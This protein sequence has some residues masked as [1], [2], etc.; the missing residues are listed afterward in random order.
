MTSCHSGTAKARFLAMILVLIVA[1]CMNV[2]AQQRMHPI[3]ADKMTA[4]QKKAVEEFQVARRQ[5]DVT[6]PWM[7]LLRV[8]EVMT[9]GR[10][11]RAHVQS[12]SVLGP[13]FTELVILLT[14]REWTQQ[15]EWNAHHQ[16]AIKAGLKAEF[17]QAVAEGRRPEQMAEDEQILYDF[18]GELHRNKSVSDAT[19]AR[20][21]SKFGEEGIVEATSIQGF[22]TL[23]AMAM[24]VA[25]TPVPAGATP[26]L[27]PFPR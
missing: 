20:A 12:R 19:Y 16:A 7:V 25:R 21:L 6:G 4:E 24:N 3:P 2:R 8:P 14:A 27:A 1:P 11:M 10:M 9:L 22:Y 18:C 15:Y 5:T 23:L 13:K 17:V 26:L